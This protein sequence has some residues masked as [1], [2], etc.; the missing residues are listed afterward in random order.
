MKPHP[1]AALMLQYA[2][3]AAENEKPWELWFYIRDVSPNVFANIPLKSNPIWDTDIKYFRKPQTIQING[4][5]VPEPYR[6]EMKEGQDFYV[7][8]PT[9]P[10]FCSEDSW[11][12]GVYDVSMRNRGLI[13]LTLEPA[14]IHGKAMAA[15]TNQES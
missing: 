13:H 4:I 14:A 11:D 9:A 6:G 10:N 7:A 1:H 8:R 15:P 2:K 3:D 5:E 12:G